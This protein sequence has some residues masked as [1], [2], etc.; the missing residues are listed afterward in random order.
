MISRLLYSVERSLRYLSNHPQLGFVLILIFVLPALFLVSGQRFLEVGRTNQDR[1]QKDRVGLMQDAF[2]SILYASDFSTST[3]QREI[4]RVAE[5][6]PDI[7]DFSVSELVA[8]NLNVIAALDSTAV[9]SST[10]YTDLQRSAAVRTDDSIIYEINTADGRY[11]LV[12][13]AIE[14]HPGNFYFITTEITLKGIDDL[15]ASREKAAVLSLIYIY[16]FLLALAYWHVRM[17]DYHYLYKEAERTISTKD[18]FMNMMAHELRAPLTVMR[19]YASLI[20]ED[21]TAKTAHEQAGRIVDSSERLI[22]IVNDVLD[23]ARLQSGKMKVEPAL[24]NVTEIVATVV[25]DQQ[26]AAKAKNIHLCAE[27]VE[28]EHIAYIDKV[29]LH[30]ALTNLVSNAIKY[31]PQGS[32]TLA[33]SKRYKKI[34]IR[35]KDTGTGISFEDQQKL[36]APFFRVSNNEVKKI[37]GSGLGMWITKQLIELMHG[38]IAVESIKGVGTHLVVQLPAEVP[39]LK[40]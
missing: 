2:V 37:T 29:R 36:F 38:T 15:F 8:G 39:S 32:I 23:V 34:E 16:A 7:A 17:T 21:E 40:N 20:L 35:V 28:I 30:Q 10:V 1:L 11:W 3:V 6:N 25:S 9:G 14:P 5:L 12:Y 18:Q 26:V 4:E 31:T 13:R 24:H 33:L 27:G 22:T 19:G